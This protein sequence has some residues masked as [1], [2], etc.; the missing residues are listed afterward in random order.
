MKLSKRTLWLI[1]GAVVLLDGVLA[2]SYFYV[3]VEMLVC[4]TSSST[5]LTVWV[6]P[7]VTAWQLD[8]IARNAGAGVWGADT[9]RGAV[10]LDGSPPTVWILEAPC[11]SEAPNEIESS[12]PIRRVEAVL[13]AHPEVRSV[14]DPNVSLPPNTGSPT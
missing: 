4:P 8:S 7:G 11:V 5:F 13:L 2:F 6:N 9:V 14:F 10:P 12:A 1:T 3:H